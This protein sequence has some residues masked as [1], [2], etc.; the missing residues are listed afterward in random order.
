MNLVQKNA[1]EALARWQLTLDDLRKQVR[2][3]H[4]SETLLL[5]GSVPEGLSS[6]ASD[7]DLMIIG[8]QEIDGKLVLEATD[9]DES[10]E[11]LKN[12]QKINV[13]YW[14]SSELA[15]LR[16]RFNAAVTTMKDPADFKKMQVLDQSQFRLLHRLRNG[17]VL[18]NP[19]RAAEW[20]RD[21]TL[22]SLPE[23]LTLYWVM[24]HYIFR[25]DVIAQTQEDHALSAL[26][27]LRLAIDCIAAAL[28][29]SIEETNPYP[30][31]RVRLLERNRATLGQ[32]EVDMLLGYLFPAPGMEIK[33]Y[34]KDVFAFCDKL[35][36]QCLKRQPAIRATLMIANNRFPFMKRLDEYPATP[37]PS[38]T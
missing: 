20:R 24:C 3:L 8:D 2:P 6:A 30:K 5:V 28:L 13:E 26:W 33:G 27:M 1:E 31:W 18:G 4:P 9:F 34:L 29:A 35:I 11:R 32:A 36:G 16:Q 21:M 15:G 14:R 22:D 12:G 25:E 19:E 38:T 23:Y 17:L 7:I 37:V 10:V